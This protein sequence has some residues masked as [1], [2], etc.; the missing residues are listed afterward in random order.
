VIDP[1]AVYQSNNLF[2]YAV[3]YNNIEF[4]RNLVRRRLWDDSTNHDGETPL[5]IARRM[6]H[7][8]IIQLVSE[9]GLAK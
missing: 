9:A 7:A 8:E 5:D 2:H 6:K 3:W 1:Y 4:V